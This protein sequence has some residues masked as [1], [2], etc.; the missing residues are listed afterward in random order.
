MII[1]TSFNIFRQNNE[2]LENKV[3]TL[4]EEIGLKR[5]IDLVSK[6]FIY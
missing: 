4:C 2:D 5:K 1:F 6:I 3:K